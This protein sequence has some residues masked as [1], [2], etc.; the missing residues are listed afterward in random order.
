MMALL[1]Q[2]CSTQQYERLQGPVGD[3]VADAVVDVAQYSANVAGLFR[4]PKGVGKFP[5]VVMLHGCSGLH[6]AVRWGL[7]NHARFLAQQGYASLIIDSFSPRGIRKDEVCNDRSQLRAARDYRQA[8]VRRAVQYLRSLPDI[9]ANNLFLMGQSNGGSVALMIAA[10]PLTNVPWFRGIV[11]YYPWCG[12]LQ[13][14]IHTPLLVIGAGKDRWVSPRDCVSRQPSI[15]G[16]PYRAVVYDDAYHSFDLP[17]RKQVFEGRQIGGDSAALAD[18]QKQMVDWF[19]Q[20]KVA[21]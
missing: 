2:G 9:D 18:S 15:R 5:A 1:V 7:R 21:Q 8:D 4:K 16:A 17:L 6:G 20:F 10:R 13:G 19:S 14:T 12:V 3:V 11:A